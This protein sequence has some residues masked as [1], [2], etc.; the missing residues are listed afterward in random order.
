MLPSF[1]FFFNL[2]LFVFEQI[3]TLASSVKIILERL[4]LDVFQLYSKET[5]QA[6]VPRSVSTRVGG[7]L[8]LAAMGGVKALG[9]HEGDEGKSPV[10]KNTFFLTPLV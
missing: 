8:T 9:G 4:V 7:V 10:P 3:Y 5:R 2:L 6:T 1:P